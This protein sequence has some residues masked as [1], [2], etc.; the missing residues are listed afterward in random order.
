MTEGIGP[1][2][3][4]DALLLDLLNEVREIAAAVERLEHD[5][6][7][8]RPVATQQPK[9]VVRCEAMQPVFIR[10]GF[11][12]DRDLTRRIVGLACLVD[13]DGLYAARLPKD[14]LSP[15]PSRAAGSRSRA[16]R[17][18]KGLT[19][20]HGLQAPQRRQALAGRHLVSGIDPD[21]EEVIAG[22]LFHGSLSLLLES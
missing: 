14:L 6:L 4:G 16:E 12:A 7:T 2:R 15:A 13:K 22:R 3:L 18:E 9:A 10:R 11:E 19:P 8:N 1:D 5:L 17:Q 21:D 20:V